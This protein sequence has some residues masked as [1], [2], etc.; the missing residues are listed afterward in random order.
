MRL[1]K[2]GVLDEPYWLAAPPVGPL[3]FFA[4]G[5]FSFFQCVS[6]TIIAL[7]RYTVIMYPTKHEKVESSLGYD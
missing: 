5:F 2:Y 1:L 4:V 3:F 7:N 6:H